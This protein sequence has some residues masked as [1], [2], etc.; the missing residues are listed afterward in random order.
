MDRSLV[1]IAILIACALTGCRQQSSSGSIRLDPALETL[2]PDDT[3]FIMGADIDAIR[4]TSVYQKHIGIVDLPR[5][6]EFT[7]Q[8]GIDPRKDLSEVLSTSNGKSSVFMARGKFS[9]TDLEARL[10]KQG[11]ARS[12]YKG[13]NFFGDDKYAVV[14]LNSTTALAGSTGS[15]KSIVDGRSKPRRG[16]PPALAARVHSIRAGSQIWAA[17]IGGVQ[18]LK[19]TVPEGSNLAAVIG[20]LRGIDSAVL[21][22]DLR[23]GFD[24]NGDALCKSEDNAKQ[25]RM[26]L[27]AV[28]GFGR[29]STPDNQPDLL[30]VYDAIQIDQVQTKV[31]VTAHVPPELVDK[32]VDL[33][34]K[35]R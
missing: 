28:I 20:L 16:L 8:T 33:W 18:G 35:R 32:F 10:E 25:L 4:N 11:A 22:M 30:K 5:L 2:V 34:V 14:F 21:G 7:R 23:N 3:L 26:A 31:I 27:K 19:V 29:L 24:L 9:T 1:A 12:A 13:Y 17:F 15:L 6:N